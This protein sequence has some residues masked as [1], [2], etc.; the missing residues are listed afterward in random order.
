MRVNTL[1][2]RW[3]GGW[4]ERKDLASIAAVGR[5]EARLDLG[6]IT[7]LPEAH[8]VAD[9]QL[10]EFA[11]ERTQTDIGIM[12]AGSDVPY[13]DFNVGDTVTVEG[14]SHRVLGLTVSVDQVTGRPIYIPT[15]NDDIVLGPDERVLARAMSPS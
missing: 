1:L 12:P 8:R 5:I 15:L 6:S 4:T 10:A 7:S 14:V 9:A 3:A 11:R 2:V 13:V